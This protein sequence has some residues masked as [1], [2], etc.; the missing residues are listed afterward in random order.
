[1]SYA[2]RFLL[3]FFRDQQ[4]WERM[5]FFCGVPLFQGLSARQLGRVTQVLQHRRYTAGEVLFTEGQV[6]KAVFI[7]ESGKV[8]I[9]RTAPNGESRCLAIMSSGQIFGEMAL[10]DNKERTASA[11]V[12]EDGV[13]HFLYTSSLNALIRR[14]PD[15]GVII[16]RNMAILLSCLLRRANLELDQ[17]IPF[18]NEL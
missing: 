15:I 6:G 13:I 8:E 4:H 3:K 12:L 16:L 7:I 2:G 10:L 1:M 5:S 18:P 14:H 17:R 9:R 11:S